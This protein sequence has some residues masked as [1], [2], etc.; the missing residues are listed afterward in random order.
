MSKSENSFEN[1]YTKKLVSKW[2]LKFDSLIEYINKN[3]KLPDQINGSREE[4]LLYSWY[5]H[6]LSNFKGNMGIVSSIHCKEKWNNYIMNKHHKFNLR[7]RKANNEFSLS[8]Q[9]KWLDR[10][11]ELDK[12]MDKHKRFPLN[13][14]PERTLTNW[15]YQQLK[16]SKNNSGIPS[17][18]LCKPYW[19]K[20]VEKHKNLFHNKDFEIWK[21]KLDLLKKFVHK[22]KRIPQKKSTHNIE[23][24]LYVWYW[25]QEERSF[26]NDILNGSEKKLLWKEFKESLKPYT[27]SEIEKQMWLKKMSCLQIFINKNNNLPKKKDGF[28]YEWYILQNNNYVKKTAIFKNEWVNLVWKNFFIKYKEFIPMN[29][30]LKTG[31]DVESSINCELDNI[32]SSLED[33]INSSL[34][35]SINSSLEEQS[36]TNEQ[37]KTT[38]KYTND[39]DCIDM[40]DDFTMFDENEYDIF[41]DNIEFDKSISS[42]RKFDE[43]FLFNY[44]S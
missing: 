42:K 20:F 21:F 31:I 1:D 27:R 28:L 40:F 4:K 19:E 26:D 6:Q 36:F 15:Y 37:S 43:T 16:F 3:S 33:N 22:K 7:E 12:F 38:S 41:F 30:I 23:Y 34:E 17:T 18:E 9:Q 14:Y 29:H 5:R 35:D 10:L 24:S 44:D 13:K 11:Y 32:N 39:I 8:V 2:N 25:H